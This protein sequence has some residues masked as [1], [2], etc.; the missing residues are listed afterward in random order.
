MNYYSNPYGIDRM[1]EKEKMENERVKK[2][3]KH[4]DGNSKSIKKYWRKT[5]KN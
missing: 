5:R 2:N 3:G 1:K 4:N